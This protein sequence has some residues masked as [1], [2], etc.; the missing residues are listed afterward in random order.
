MITKG[1]KILYAGLI[2]LVLLGGSVLA[3]DR[4]QS[5]NR[6]QVRTAFIEAL[7][8]AKNPSDLLAAS[9]EL[10]QVYQD[11]TPILIPRKTE[12]SSSSVCED[13]ARMIREVIAAIDSDNPGPHSLKQLIAQLE[14]LTRSFNNL[15]CPRSLL[16]DPDGG[17]HE[18]P[19]Q[20]E[21]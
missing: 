14:S 18:G 3:Y 20:I 19:T 1:K 13:L 7:N 12:A 9:Q 16:D 15:H 5:R 17:N 4:Q 6:D 2:A 11:N 21:L 8:Q 10:N